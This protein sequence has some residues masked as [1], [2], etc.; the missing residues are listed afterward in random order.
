MARSGESLQDQSHYMC[1]HTEVW[2]DRQCSATLYFQTEC[3]PKKVSEMQNLRPHPRPTLSDIQ[4]WGPAVCFNK[5]SRRLWCTL[6]LERHCSPT[7]WTTARGKRTCVARAPG[8]LWPCCLP[9]PHP[10]TPSLEWVTAGP[11]SGLDE[12]TATPKSSLLWSTGLRPRWFRVPRG[13]FSEKKH[14]REEQFHW[15]EGRVWTT[16]FPIRLLE[17]LEV[18]ALPP[19]SRT[20]PAPGAHKYPPYSRRWQANGLCQ[21]G[22]RTDS[23]TKVWNHVPNAI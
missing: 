2:R 15:S 21:Q 18:L 9:K 10:P 14:Y 3:I 16:I 4:G 7:P 5:T 17:V 11:E 1:S 12:G 19:S 13:P 22:M 23:A 8:H 20:G 6:P